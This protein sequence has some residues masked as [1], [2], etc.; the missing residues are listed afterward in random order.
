MKKLRANGQNNKIL[1]GVYTGVFSVND[2]DV[3]DTFIDFSGWGKGFILING[4]HLGR[5]WNVGPQRTLYVPSPFL[6]KGAN[7][8][9]IVEL[10]SDYY[11]C[12]APHKCQISSVDHPIWKYK[13]VVELN[14]KFTPKKSTRH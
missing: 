7:R 8:I 2:V 4:H 5:Y 10:L 12:K 9:F 3:G 13:N 6:R 11:D 1:E 14:D